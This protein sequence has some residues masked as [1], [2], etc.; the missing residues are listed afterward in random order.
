MQRCSCSVP[1]TSGWV[2]TG[3]ANV[4]SMATIAPCGVAAAPQ[5][6]RD[7]LLLWMAWVAARQ[8]STARQLCAAEAQDPQKQQQAWAATPPRR[9]AA[10]H[11]LVAQLRDAWHVHAA[12]VGIGGVLTEEQRHLAGASRAGPWRRGECRAP[13]RRPRNTQQQGEGL[14]ARRG[15]AATA[16]P[17]A[18]RSAGY[19]ASENSRGSR[20]LIRFISSTPAA[21]GAAPAH[22]RAPACLMGR[23]PWRQCPSW[24]GTAG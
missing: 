17:P 6:Q 7:G 21:P 3:V 24:A 19:P 20:S 4:E 5:Q 14:P 11:L 13:A 12:H 16:H 2:L 22:P 1:P 8:R 10:A 18:G 23:S 9:R 15:G